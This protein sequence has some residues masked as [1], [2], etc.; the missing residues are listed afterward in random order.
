MQ[1]STGSSEGESAEDE[2]RVEL[3]ITVGDEMF[4][5]VD[6]V[7]SG[8]L[9]Y[10]VDSVLSLRRWTANARVFRCSRSAREMKSRI[11][12]SEDRKRIFEPSTVLLDTVAH[13]S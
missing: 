6:W 1:S 10:L 9:S 12:R 2:D 4:E 3:S 5:S 7:E 13:S 11:Y 8:A